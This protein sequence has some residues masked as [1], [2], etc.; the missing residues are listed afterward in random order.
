MLDAVSQLGILMLLLLTGMETDLTL[1]RRVG[2]AAIGVSVAGV[3]MPFA[4]GFA[5]GEML[6]DRMLPD[7]EPAARHR[8]VPRHRAVDLLGQDRRHGRARDEFHAPQHRPDHRASAIIDDTVGW[9]IIA[10]TFG[11]APT[12]AS[13]CASL[14]RAVLGTLRVPGR[15]LHDRPAHRV[16]LIRWA[17][18]NFV[19]ECRSSPPSW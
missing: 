16:P 9:I 1:V 2:R 5:L 13:T 7:P 15:Q 11:L 14:A 18:D 6:P 12:A 4:C 19:S 8:A 17:N 10:I 3:A